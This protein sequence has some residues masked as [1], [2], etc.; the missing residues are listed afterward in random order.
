MRAHGQCTTVKQSKYDYSCEMFDEIAPNIKL[1]SKFHLNLYSDWISF[2][3]AF[4]K[5]CLDK[6]TDNIFI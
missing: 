1:K 5:N 2:F 4:W 3:R 6:R